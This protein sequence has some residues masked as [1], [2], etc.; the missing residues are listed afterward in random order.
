MGDTAQA[1]ETIGILYSSYQEWPLSNN[2]LFV[3]VIFS[4]FL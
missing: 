1:V 2:A 4:H 3:D